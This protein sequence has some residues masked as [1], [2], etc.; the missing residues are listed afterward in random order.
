MSRQFPTP[1]GLQAAGYHCVLQ[2]SLLALAFKKA[3][4][5]HSMPNSPSAESPAPSRQNTPTSPF[6]H[7]SHNTASSPLHSNSLHQSQQ[8]QHTRQHSSSGGS[9]YSPRAVPQGLH[10]PQSGEGTFKGPSAIPARAGP[11]CG[12]EL[13]VGNQLLMGMLTHESAALL[14]Q[15]L[16]QVG[17]DGVGGVR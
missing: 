9:S 10:A 5:A 4:P 7:L 1:F 16:L 13:S 14:V 8:Q 15:L 11:P 17:H 6:H 3:A 12:W 2:E